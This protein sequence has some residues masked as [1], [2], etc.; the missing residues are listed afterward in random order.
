MMPSV[1][2]M[3]LQSNRP[4]W[5]MDDCV[6]EV[7]LLVWVG[8][9]MNMQGLAIVNV[10]DCLINS[11]CYYTLYDFVLRVRGQN[12]GTANSLYS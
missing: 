8:L 1:G 7:T 9:C 11:S 4:K 3:P 10:C 6:K 2:G 12:K 5:H